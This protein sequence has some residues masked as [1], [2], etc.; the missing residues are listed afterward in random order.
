MLDSRHL[1][2]LQV[3]DIDDAWIFARLEHE[4]IVVKLPLLLCELFLE[5]FLEDSLSISTPDLKDEATIVMIS[6]FLIENLN[7]EDRVV[8]GANNGRIV[9]TVALDS[10][11]TQV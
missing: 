2:L 6:K 8:S 10:V 7:L 1:S 9:V 11:M 3:H 4:D 5:Y